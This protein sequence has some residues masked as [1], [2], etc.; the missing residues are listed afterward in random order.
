[1]YY[2]LVSLYSHTNH[3]VNNTYTL[4]WMVRRIKSFS[5]KLVQKPLA[6]QIHLQHLKSPSK[7]HNFQTIPS[8]RHFIKHIKCFLKSNDIINLFPCHPLANIPKFQLTFITYSIHMHYSLINLTCI[9]GHLQA[10]SWLN[11]HT[12]FMRAPKITHYQI[13]QT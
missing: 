5:I 6:S 7:N 8:H 11:T 3:K 12:C 2:N 4:P 9:Q 10:S 1:M 13:F